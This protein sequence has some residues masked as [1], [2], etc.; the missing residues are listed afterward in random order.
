[1]K[2][3]QSIAGRHRLLPV[4]TPV[5]FGHVLVSDTRTKA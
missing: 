2:L 4:D 3:R 5:V 1:M